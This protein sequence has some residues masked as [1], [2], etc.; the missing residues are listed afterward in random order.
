MIDLSV[1][2]SE[3]YVEK[4]EANYDVLGKGVHEIYKTMIN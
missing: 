4:L 3:V 1:G 2:S